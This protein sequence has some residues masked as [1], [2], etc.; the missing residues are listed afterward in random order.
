MLS[1]TVLAERGFTL[2]FDPQQLPGLS[3]FQDRT[4]HIPGNP[5]VP[6]KRRWLFFPWLH[7][8]PPWIRQRHS[9]LD[10]AAV[11]E[12]S[13]WRPS[14]RPSLHVILRVH[15]VLQKRHSDF[16]STLGHECILLFFFFFK[17]SF[18]I[19][20]LRWHCNHFWERNCVLFAFCPWRCQLCAWPV[21]DQH[22][23]AE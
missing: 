2:V 1:E 11:W 22:Q 10:S 16:S 8:Q 14:S 18:C 12:I 5:L 19:L 21:G 13:S 15:S 23:L 9:S 6:G 7:P 20:L 17:L 4:S 3:Q